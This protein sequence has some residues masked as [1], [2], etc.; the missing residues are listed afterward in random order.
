MKSDDVLKKLWAIK[1]K[2]ADE[3]PK[4]F[5][6]LDTLCKEWQ[7][8]RTTAREWVMALEAEG[9]IKRLRLRFLMDAVSR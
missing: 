7:V 4:G 8:H 6:D 1:A 9:K 2:K 5:K 3:V